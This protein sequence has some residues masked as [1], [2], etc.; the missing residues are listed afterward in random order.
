MII[1][2][3]AGGLG[4]QMF[5]YAFARSLSLRVGQPVM[6]DVEPI[7]N[8]LSHNGLELN[9][10]FAIQIQTATSADFR[11]VLGVFGRPLVRKILRQQVS[12]AIRPASIFV[13]SSSRY[14]PAVE[15]LSGNNYICG[16]WQSERYFA[17]H[18]DVI[19]N[20]FKF[21][22]PLSIDNQRLIDK[23]VTSESVSIHIRRGDYIANKS[24]ASTYAACDGR[25]YLTAVRL[26]AEKYKEPTFYVFS[27]EPQWA[28][29]NLH[30]D[31]PT[32]VVDTNTSKMNY[33]D[34]QLMAACKSNIIANSTFS[35]WGAWLNSNRNKTVVAPKCWFNSNTVDTGDL[36]P[37]SWV[38]V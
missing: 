15:R 5:Q 3:I 16:Y 37:R 34:M 17:E 8:G 10:V 33:V 21:T 38:S 35:W 13:E 28:R 1:L 6:Y 30:I 19:R 11:N 9:Q 26:I 2:R 31:F 14:M 4:N 12:S 24:A 29:D 25:Y 32:V 20:D 27:D 22:N 36:I 18:S 23:I 7:E